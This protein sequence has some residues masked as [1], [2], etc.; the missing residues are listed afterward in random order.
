MVPFLA[1]TQARSEFITSLDNHVSLRGNC[2]NVPEPSIVLWIILSVIWNEGQSRAEIH[3]GQESRQCFCRGTEKARRIY[4]S[5]TQ[6]DCTILLIICVHSPANSLYI[7]P[8]S[9][10]GFW[11]FQDDKPFGLSSRHFEKPK[12]PSSVVNDFLLARITDVNNEEYQNPC[13]FT[14]CQV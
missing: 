10:Q 8:S 2:N 7:F 1:L 9:S 11:V 3:K 5:S 14:H 4:L 13:F 6:F 12:A